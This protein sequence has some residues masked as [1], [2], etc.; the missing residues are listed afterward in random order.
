M[1]LVNKTPVPAVVRV[2]PIDEATARAGLLVA[3]A[4]FRWGPMPPADVRGAGTAAVELDDQDPLPIFDRDEETEL[5]PLPADVEPREDGSFEVLVVGEAHAANDRPVRSRQVGVQ[6]GEVRNTL[7]VHGDRFW[8][9]SGGISPAEPFLRMPL[10]Y[11]RAFGGTA[12]VQ[13]DDASYLD[14]SH[15]LNPLGRGFDAAAQAQLLGKSLECPAGYP[16]LVDDRRP[17]SNLEDPRSPITGPH[18]D[19]E[20]Y[21]WT[22][23]PRSIGFSQIRRI[24]QVRAGVEP[25]PDSMADETIKDLYR[26]AHPD[27]RMKLPQMPV[28]VALLGLTPDE[29]VRFLLPALQIVA[30]Y[31]VGERTGVLESSPST[32]VLLPSERRF[33]LVYRAPFHFEPVE[34]QEACLRLRLVHS[35]GLL[36]AAGAKPPI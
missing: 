36:A 12:V 33:T 9:P 32:L 30:D 29:M 19:P 5:G 13:I 21:C 24:R 26:R 28:E 20:P 1:E 17:L 10:T 7:T 35:P 22:A 27:W 4:T 15:P 8:Q 6:V 16:R 2:T 34:G 23:I 3:K 25:D 14:I 11:E 31:V 18:D